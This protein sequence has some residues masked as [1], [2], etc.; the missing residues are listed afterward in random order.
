MVLLSASMISLIP[1]VMLPVIG[2]S[3]GVSVGDM[4][5]GGLD[6]V[7]MPVGSTDCWVEGRALDVGATEADGA[8]IMFCTKLR[9][10]YSTKIKHIS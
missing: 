3:V 8:V 4:D 10:K 2:D 5:F 7:G 6:L 1:T 9:L